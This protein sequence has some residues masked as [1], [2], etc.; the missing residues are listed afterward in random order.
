MNFLK[1][2][3]HYFPTSLFLV[4]SLPQSHVTV[5]GIP[6]LAS[7]MHFLQTILVQFALYFPY[8]FPNVMSECLLSLFYAFL[9]LY[10]ISKLLVIS[11][12]LSSKYNI[13]LKWGQYRLSQNGSFSKEI[14][15]CPNIPRLTLILP[16]VI[17][18]RFGHCWFSHQSYCVH[19]GSN[20]SHILLKKGICNI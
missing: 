10:Y 2:W 3:D 14:S 11:S 4:L 12:Y 17:L 7:V 16:M 8:V 9:K 19:S 1:L 15:V 18:E 20:S 6:L 13:L 5:F